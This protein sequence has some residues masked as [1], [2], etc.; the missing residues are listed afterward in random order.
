MA[1]GLFQGALQYAKN[2]I[3]DGL[4]YAKDLLENYGRRGVIA[5][6]I[7]AI[8]AGALGPTVPQVSA[9]E[10]LSNSS[11]PYT[12]RAATSPIMLAGYWTTDARSGQAGQ[13]ITLA[14][15]A[16]TG[17]TLELAVAGTGTGLY[18]PEIP[19][20]GS[21]SLYQLSIGAL[22][23][24][25]TS[26]QRLLLE[27]MASGQ[28]GGLWPYLLV[29]SPP[30]PSPTPSATYTS[31]P[32]PPPSPTRTRTPT[33]TP[34]PTYTQTPIPPPSSTPTTTPFPSVTPTPSPKPSRTPTPTPLNTPVRTATPTPSPTTVVYHYETQPKTGD[35]VMVA[36]ASQLYYGSNSM[37]TTLGVGPK[38]DS[39]KTTE[40]DGET[41]VSAG[42]ISSGGNRVHLMI[43]DHMRRS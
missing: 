28:Q 9:L 10:V 23:L 34:P 38:D 21:L 32:T 40:I 30:P 37:S 3:T 22:D 2:S 20:G 8:G 4:Q 39:P 15:I 25:Q 13:S 7:A 19:S 33:R 27:M 17:L 11:A 35:D 41:F 1:N 18:I 29:S 36:D 16:P 12:Q 26:A 42:T 14:A 31:S 43:P 5:T 6:T 24:Q